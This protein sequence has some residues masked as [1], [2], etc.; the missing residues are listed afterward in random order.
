MCDLDIRLIPG[1]TKSRLTGLYVSS[2]KKL[3]E[4]R[5]DALLISFAK[6]GRTWLR[7]MIGKAIAE[8]YHLDGD[9]LDL[10]LIAKREPSIPVL[11]ETHDGG[12]VRARASDVRHSKARYRD[13][14]VLFMVR[15]PRDTVVSAYFQASKRKRVFEAELS[16]YLRSP[17]GSIDTI[18]EFCN[19][20]ARERTVPK[21]FL[22]IRYEDLHCD[23]ACELRTVLDFLGLE[24]IQEGSIE[25]AV[26]FASFENMRRLEMSGGMGR[27]RLV[28][29]P[30]DASDVESYKT[31]RGKAGG[32]RDYLSEEDIEYLDRRI[33]SELDPYYGY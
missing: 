3:R 4:S 14:K 12:T 29:R 16:E 24:N 5:A 1:S 2:R 32:Y 19:T 27:G 28:L 30:A 25:R 10:D 21:A 15:D 7:V 8:H 20:W 11:V 9:L 17:V 18:L 22:L 23:P 33:S 31:R 13:K 26:E 6:S